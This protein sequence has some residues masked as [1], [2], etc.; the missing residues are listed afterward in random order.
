[1]SRSFPLG[2]VG[3]V[4]TRKQPRGCADAGQCLQKAGEPHPNGN[5]H[6]RS[7]VATFRQHFIFIICT[8]SQSPGPRP[9]LLFKPTLHFQIASIG[10]ILIQN[11]S[12]LGGQRRRGGF[13]LVRFIAFWRAEVVRL[14]PVG[15]LV[16]FARK[17]SAAQRGKVSARDSRGKSRSQAGGACH[18]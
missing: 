7:A 5:G 11:V 3:E 9:W 15:H 6:A 8:F 2:I 12:P 4:V 1:M 13:F 16:V 17:R 10:L 14:G 18:A